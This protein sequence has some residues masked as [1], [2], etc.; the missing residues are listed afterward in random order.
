M[1]ASALI[2]DKS[3]LRVAAVDRDGKVSLK[4]ITIARDAGKTVEVASG[5]TREDN[6]IESPPD[7]IV[8]GDKV[9]V[10]APPVSAKN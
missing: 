9:N 3:G 5:L 7:G 6:V 8:D 4:T 1:P 10:K 2:F